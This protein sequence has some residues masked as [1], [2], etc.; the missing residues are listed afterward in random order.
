VESLLPPLDEEPIEEVID[1]IHEIAGEFTIEFP[2]GVKSGRHAS[3]I[4]SKGSMTV[5]R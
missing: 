1:L 5:K 3:V 2:T 4:A